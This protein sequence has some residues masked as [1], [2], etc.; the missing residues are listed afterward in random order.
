MSQAITEAGLDLIKGFEG[1][2]SQPYLCPAGVVTIGYGST[3]GLDGRPLEASHRKITLGEG[4]SLLRRDLDQASRSVDL[5]VDVP[6]TGD[7]FSS[8]VSFCYN[9]GSGAL[10]ASTLRAKL[11]RGDYL[12]ASEEFGR[13]RF[14]GGKVLAGLVR[15]RAAERRLFLSGFHG[16]RQRP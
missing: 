10:A 7:Q 1:F 9:V 12:G 11:N 4:E 2:S 16:S 8:L 3:R 15:R 13:W 5:L 6:L 14:A